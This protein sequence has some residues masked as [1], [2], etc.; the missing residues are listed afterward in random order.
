[1][2]KRN[3]IRDNVEQLLEKHPK[4]R[5]SDKL[6]CMMYWR[7]FDGLPINDE[8]TSKDFANLFVLKSTNFE[9]IR[10]ARQLIQQD[11]MY[12]PTEEKVKKAR[13]KKQDLMVEA[14]LEHREVVN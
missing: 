1:M 7:D 8:K 10:R 4:T 11:G 2:T 3:N 12:L 6:L 13:R 14:I 5:N 9:S